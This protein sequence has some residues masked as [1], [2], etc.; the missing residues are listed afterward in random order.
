M[1]RITAFLIMIAVAG[2]AQASLLVHESFLDTGGSAYDVSQTI[3]SG[4]NRE[5]G[6]TAGSWSSRWTGGD[7]SLETGGLTYATATASLNV[8]GGLQATGSGG[9]TATRRPIANQSSPTWFSFLL[10]VSSTG[11]GSRLRAGASFNNSSNS[12][13]MWGIQIDNTGNTNIAIKAHVNNTT[14]GSIS[15]NKDETYL[16]VG[17][18]DVFDNNGTL[19][20]RIKIWVNP[21][22]TL[23]DPGTAGITYSRN[24]DNRAGDGASGFA[25]QIGANTALDDI[26][27]G[28]TYADV[29]PHTVIPE[30]ASMAMV[31]VGLLL[32]AR[33]CRRS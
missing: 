28:T 9:G 26:R 25:M 5:K 14:S 19:E 30:P 32:T 27:M 22:M 17:L 13:L 31:G 2:A 33:R 11:T 16:V 8:G 1:Q 10:N 6:P 18:A 4:T 3:A 23:L 7:G 21:D 15:I 29:V 24:H 12:N 20:D